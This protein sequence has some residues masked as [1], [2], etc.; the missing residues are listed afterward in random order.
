[1]ELSVVSQKDA[2]LYKIS[3]EMYLLV[4]LSKYNGSQNRCNLV[5]HISKIRA[6]LRQFGVI[7]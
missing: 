1:M 2:H 7:R 6:K 3:L 5:S 4:R